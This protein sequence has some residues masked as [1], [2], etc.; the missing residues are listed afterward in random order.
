MDFERINLLLDVVHK[1]LNV[2]NTNRI[3]DEAMAE[4]REINLPLAVE[5]VFNEPAAEANVQ[6]ELNVGG[7][8]L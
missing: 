1:T 7:R 2:P 8:R 3:R 4:L 6:E 5:A